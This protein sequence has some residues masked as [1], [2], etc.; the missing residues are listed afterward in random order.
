M[1][2]D[3]CGREQARPALARWW[4]FFTACGETFALQA[5][6]SYFVG[7]YLFGKGAQ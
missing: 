3:V 6:Q 4:V 1:L 2:A 7:H 5:G